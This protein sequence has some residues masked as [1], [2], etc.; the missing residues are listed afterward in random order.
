MPTEFEAKMSS[1]TLRQL[2]PGGELVNARGLRDGGTPW[3]VRARSTDGN[4]VEAVLRVG[5]DDDI[6]TEAAALRFAKSNGL[7]VPNLIN[8]RDVS[9]DGMLLI[10]RVPGGS[11][12]PVEV[13]ASRLRT[14]GA[15]AASLSLLVPPPGFERRTRSISGVDFAQLRR[16]AEPQPLLVRAEAIVASHAPRSSEGMVHGDLWQGNSLWVGHELVSVIDW[17][18][19]GVGP[20]GVDLGSLRLDAAFV[21]G[22]GAVDYVL[23]GWESVGGAASDVP[24]W[25]LV[26]A[27]CTPPEIDWFAETTRAQGRPD[28]TMALLR[29]RRDEFL[30]R[31]LDSWAEDR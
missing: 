20:A 31:A 15:F 14:L 3:L 16:N 18:C 30:E 25:D 27:L 2:A 19:A 21:F 1:W 26:A 6:R 13:N 4:E 24:Y 11:A 23:E 29:E 22:T 17:D 28:L 7:P 8:V 5:P 9:P 12:I 10:E